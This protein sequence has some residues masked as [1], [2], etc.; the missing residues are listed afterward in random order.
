MG[1]SAE[2]LERLRE[3]IRGL[4]DR[5]RLATLF[6]SMVEGRAGPMSD[7]DVAVL[8]KEG[9]DRLELVADLLEAVTGALPVTEDK[10]DILFLDGVES[11]PLLYRAVVRGVPLYCEDPALYAE[12]RDR[13]LSQ[14]LDF[15]VFL[16]KME[17]GERFRRALSR[18]LHEAAQA[19]ADH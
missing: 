7:V 3:G 6:G 18:W 19:P 5:L 10:V 11:L 9:V 13:I 4:S 8:P 2:D 16:R 14:Y 12:L 1:V 17:L 15:A